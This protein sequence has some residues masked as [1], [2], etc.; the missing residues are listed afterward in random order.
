M[1]SAQYPLTQAQA[2]AGVANFKAMMQTMVDPSPMPPTGESPNGSEISIGNGQIIDSKGRVWT[3]TPNATGRGWNVLRNGAQL[4]NGGIATT[5]R[6]CQ[7]QIFATNSAGIWPF[8]DTID[9]WGP[10]IPPSQ[11]CPKTN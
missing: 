5:I 2:D 10:S 9:N 11:L 4:P 6:Y 8:V 1:V 7:H 3:V